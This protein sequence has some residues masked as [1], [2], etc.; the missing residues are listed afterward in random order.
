MLLTCGYVLVCCRHSYLSVLLFTNTILTC[1]WCRS[2]CSS[3]FITCNILIERIRCF[4]TPEP[5]Q[6]QTKHSSLVSSS[7]GIVS[8]TSSMFTA[9]AKQFHIIHKSSLSQVILELNHTATSP[10][11]DPY[12]GWGGWPRR[13]RTKSWRGK[14]PYHC[15]LV[16]MFWYVIWVLAFGHVLVCY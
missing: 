15:A 9:P 5:Y 1:C 11:K 7:T 13:G 8:I 6:L 14:R 12:R 16:V 3:L 10:F 2:N 4:F